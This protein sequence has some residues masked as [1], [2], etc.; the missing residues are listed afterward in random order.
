[1]LT[2]SPY[3]YE[4][5]FSITIIIM[6]HPSR[7]MPLSRRIKCHRTTDLQD[8]IHHPSTIAQPL[9]LHQS[10]RSTNRSTSGA[11]KNKVI[12][13]CIS[14]RNPSFC[15]PK[16]HGA[17][18]KLPKLDLLRIRNRLSHVWADSQFQMAGSW[19]LTSDYVPVL[20]LFNELFLGTK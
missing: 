6:I 4:S 13:C 3:Y 19:R 12:P 9:T 10:S 2:C 14:I 11:Q 1:M 15:H 7:I 17:G 16:S 18:S 8:H 5:P 20:C